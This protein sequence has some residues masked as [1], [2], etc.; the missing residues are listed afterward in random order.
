MFYKDMKKHDSYTT[1]GECS[2]GIN[3]IQKHAV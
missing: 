3:L 2:Y 1:N